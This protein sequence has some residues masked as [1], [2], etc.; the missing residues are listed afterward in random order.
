LIKRQARLT[1]ERT[2]AI[3]RDS[4]LSYAE[5]MNEVT[6]LSAGLR[7]RG[8]R[9]ECVVGVC[10][11]R[12]LEML[13]ALL[14][15]LDAGGA[16]LPL[17]PAFPTERIAFM[18]DDSR[19][20]ALITHSGLAS[21]FAAS[22]V[23]TLLI[24]RPHEWG[25]SI[26]GPRNPAQTPN[27]IAY[28]MYTSGSTGVPKGVMVEHRSVVNFFR[29]MDEVLGTQPGVWLAVTSISFDISVLELLWTLARGFV[30]VI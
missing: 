24:D 4:R 2:A 30:V 26:E 29:G 22:T 25:A 7:G 14:A 11:E 10:L 27:S 5:L 21:R 13:I 9:A 18:L 8:V 12:S 16:Y 1:P 3:W 23:Q 19:A 17:D 6:R 15:V 28:L 20:H